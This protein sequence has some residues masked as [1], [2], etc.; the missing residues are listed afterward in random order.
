MYKQSYPGLYYF[1]TFTFTTLGTS[2]YRGPDSSKTYANAPWR[3]GDFSI[4]NGQQYW[5]VPTNGIYQIT[6]AGAFGSYPGRVVSGQVK[7]NGGQQLIMLIGQKSAKYGGSSGGGASWVSTS[8]TLLMVAS[9]GDGIGGRSAVFSPYGNGKGNDG[10]GYLTDGLRLSQTIYNFLVPKAYINGGYGNRFEDNSLEAGFGGGNVKG[11][12]GYTGSIGDGVTGATCYA[13]ASVQ[14]FTDQ[15][16]TS[17]SAGYVKIS[18]VSPGPIN[19]VTTWSNRTSWS[20]SGVQ[21]KNSQ[22]IV[23]NSGIN[24]FM[25][26][27]TQNLPTIETSQ[28]GRTWYDFS[29]NLPV[30]SN[31]Y[32]VIYANNTLV[33]NNE[34]GL[35]SSRDGITWTNTLPSVGSGQLLNALSNI[36][37]ISSNV[38]ISS[39]GYNWTNNTIQGTNSLYKV[40]YGKGIFIG[41]SS[42]STFVYVSNDCINWYITSTSPSF[43]SN[44]ITFYNGNFVA[45]GSGSVSYSPVLSSFNPSS[46]SSL[47]SFT[48]ATFTSGG[49][50]GKTGPTLAQA[51]LGLTGT[52]SPST[53]SGTY[54]TMNSY[55]GIQQWTVPMTATYSITC[56]GA[57]TSTGYGA[58]ITI[59]Y[60]LTQGQ[61]VSIVCGQRGISSGVFC[62]GSGGS[63]VFTGSTLLVAAGGSSGTYGSSTNQN[64]SLTTTGNDGVTTATYGI[65]PGTGG[66]GPNGGGGSVGANLNNGQNVPSANGTSGS[67]GVAGNGGTSSTIFILTGSGGGGGWSSTS[68]FLGGSGGNDAGASGLDGGFGLGGGSGVSTGGYNAFGFGGGGGYGG[69]GGETWGGN[70]TGVVWTGGGGGS[71][72][73]T[74]F[75]TSSVTNNGTGYVTIQY[76][77]QVT[78]LPWTNI[79]IQDTITTLSPLNSSLVGISQSNVWYS[80]NITNWKKS[81]SLTLKNTVSTSTSLGYSVL[82]DGQYTYLTLDGVYVVNSVT[83]SV[84]FQQIAWSPKLNLYVSTGTGIVSVSNDGKIWKTIQVSSL[85]GTSAIEWSS[86]LGIFLVYCYGTVFTSNDG[87]TWNTYAGPTINLTNGHKSL[88]W[89]SSLGIFTLGE[90][91]RAHV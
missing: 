16:A 51:V 57:G 11:G 41:T 63:F 68:N 75:L 78:T 2:G 86:E 81:T 53:W 62:G 49:L 61:V 87:Y 77:P 38:Y 22:K 17:N 46:V 34:N 23:W 26:F 66:T 82:T 29:S 52:P 72:A 74:S 14:N 8:T 89:A 55:Q 30:V 31:I 84:G 5:T 44:S 70:T 4:Q 27:N 47:Y 3:T 32:D 59:Y 36:Y 54:L 33:L 83:N 39:D 15:G 7:L 18:L 28:D 91:G 48:N 6:A 40:S 43:S 71:Y 21:M 13:D 10:A 65:P 58:V 42:T 67:P 12:G 64:A 88:V 45:S 73:I 20:L 35:L 85:S 60:N 56:A 1:D 25:S 80:Q 69:G 37:F 50:V 19:Q 90:I 76:I 9:G 79:N 24:L